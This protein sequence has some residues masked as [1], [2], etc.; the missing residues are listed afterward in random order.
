MANAEAI[1]ASNDDTLLAL[2]ASIQSLTL[3]LQG[4]TAML[5]LFQTLTPRSS[6]HRG[7]LCS[8]S[9]TNACPDFACGFHQR[10][11]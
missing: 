1:P 5:K 4:K 7:N 2:I 3:A 10:R 9:V 8:A 6:K 11:D